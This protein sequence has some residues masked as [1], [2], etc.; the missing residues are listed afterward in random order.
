M[1]IPTDKQLHFLGSY[2]LVFTFFH[3]LPDA[4]AALGLVA[5]AIIV[6]GIGVAKELCDEIKYGGFSWKDLVADAAGVM[7]AAAVIYLT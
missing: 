3:W 1:K 7:A 2:G 6:M 4:E 5:V